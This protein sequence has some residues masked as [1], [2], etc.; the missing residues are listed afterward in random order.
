MTKALLT[1]LSAADLSVNSPTLHQFRPKPTVRL[2]RKGTSLYCEAQLKSS[3]QKL[4]TC[5]I[6]SPPKSGCVVFV[7]HCSHPEK[8][9][10]FLCGGLKT[11]FTVRIKGLDFVAVARHCKH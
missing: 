3:G 6:T 2:W 10:D 8:F 9:H 11:G 4:V 7:I 5:H 1:L